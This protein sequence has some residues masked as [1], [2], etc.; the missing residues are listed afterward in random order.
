VNADDQIA[1]RGARL[2]LLLSVVAE[3][4]PEEAPDG[5][6]AERLGIYD[7]LSAHPLLIVNGPDDPDGLMLRLAGF[8]DRSLAYASAGQRLAT[9]LMR[10]NRDLAVLIGA[11]LVEMRAE[12]RIRYRLTSDGEIAVG[13]LNAGYAENYRLAARFVVRRL[14]RLSGRRLR[15]SLHQWTRDLA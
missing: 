7:F 10:L 1:F 9:G 12:G 8:D 6:D 13:R 11:G 3:V 14:R 15:E 4:E 2:L 5:L